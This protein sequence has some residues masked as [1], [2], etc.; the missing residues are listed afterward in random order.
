MYIDDTGW[1]QYPTCTSV[2]AGLGA[3]RLPLHFLESS[4]AVRQEGLW[5]TFAMVG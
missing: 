1:G 5:G 3:S 4:R 2:K